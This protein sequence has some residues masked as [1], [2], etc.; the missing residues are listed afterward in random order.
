MYW[1][2]ERAMAE[3]DFA[4]EHSGTL[5]PIE[6]KAAENLKSKSLRS[7][8]DRFHPTEAWRFSLAN[9]REDQEITNVPLYAIG[10]FLS[11]EGQSVH[12]RD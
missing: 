5:V 10:P 3:L 7:Y 2:P 11:S 9:Y 4:I 12:S 1:A 6:V 8:L